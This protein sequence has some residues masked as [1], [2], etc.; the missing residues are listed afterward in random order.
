MSFQLITENLS[1]LSCQVRKNA[2]LIESWGVRSAKRIV[3]DHEKWLKS[4]KLIAEK[5]P[6]IYNS[7]IRL[8]CRHPDRN[9]WTGLIMKL[10]Y[11]VFSLHFPLV[12]VLTSFFGCNISRITEIS[13][14]T[15]GR[16]Y[17]NFIRSEKTQ[18]F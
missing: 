10:K 3:A 14:E 6:K 7:Q 8:Q 12:V 9:K 2:F 4:E 13:Y 18:M 1:T 16:C 11:P 5:A 15:R 17:L